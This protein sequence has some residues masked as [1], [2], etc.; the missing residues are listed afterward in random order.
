MSTSLGIAHDGGAAGTSNATGEQGDPPCE[1]DKAAPASG[2]A[3]CEP[4]QVTA[5]ETTA[6]RTEAHARRTEASEITH[7]TR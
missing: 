4:D 2:D 6:Q 5:K 7:Y 1:P 3:L